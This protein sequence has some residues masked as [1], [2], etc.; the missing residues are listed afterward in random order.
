MGVLWFLSFAFPTYLLDVPPLFF[1][2]LFSSCHLVDLSGLFPFL[3]SQCILVGFNKIFSFAEKEKKK[4]HAHVLGE[5]GRILYKRKARLTNRRYIVFH[6][7]T[8]AHSS[9]LCTFL[10]HTLEDFSHPYV[11]G[12]SRSSS[13]VVF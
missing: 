6:T 7:K 13:G 12:P 4:R 8:L 11:G 1:S 10:I 5:Q 9:L 3:F 2:S